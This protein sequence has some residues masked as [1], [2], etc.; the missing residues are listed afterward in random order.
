[1]VDAVHN[2]DGSITTKGANEQIDDHNAATAAEIAE[3]QTVL[4][5]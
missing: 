5:E 1:M 4:S 3:I 2:K